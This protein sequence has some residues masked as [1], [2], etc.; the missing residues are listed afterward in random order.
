MKHLVFV[1]PGRIGSAVQPYFDAEQFK[2]TVLSRREYG[3]FL[4]ADYAP[5]AAVQLLEACDAVICFAGLFELNAPAARMR[6]ANCD[7]IT[8]LAEAVH[9]RFPC[10][11][12]ITFLDARIHRALAALPEAV[13]A[14]VQSKQALAQ[15]TLERAQT[16]GRETGARV[17]AIAPGPVLPPPNRQ[18]SEKAGDCLTPR[19]TPADIA[20]AL[21]FLLETPSVTGQILYVAA[22][23]QLL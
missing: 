9:R 3:D 14:Y 22:G 19:P 17:N 6:Q 16:W 8:R 2:I 18:H 21:T 5:E 7:A 11:Q 1:G 13:R 20:T 4:S 23:Q 12:V 15:W 10:A